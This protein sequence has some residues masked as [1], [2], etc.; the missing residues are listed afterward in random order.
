MS[1]VVVDVQNIVTSFGENV[2]HNGLSLSVNRG[3][4]YA[5]LGGS[6]SGKSTLLREMIMLQK[7]SSGNITILGKKLSNISISDGDFLRRNWGVLFQSGALYSSLNVA[8]NIALPLKEYTNIENS[9]IDKIVDAKLDL[10]GLPLH[11]KSM[12]PAQLSGGMKKRAGLARALSMDPQ[13]LFL[14]E[15]TSGL[16]PISANMFDEL[17]VELRDLLGLSIVMITHDLDSI[18]NSVDRFALLAEARVVAQGTL[19]EVM[20]CNHPIIKSFFYGKRGING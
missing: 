1:E 9:L 7:P 11:V 15:P 20:K 10:V 3:E 16:D 5:L 17:I 8:Q 14:D 4:I 6:G 13:L 19:Q 12:H 18:K 2:V